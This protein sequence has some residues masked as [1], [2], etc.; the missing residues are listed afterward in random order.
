MGCFQYENVK[1]AQA[2]DL[3]DHVDAEDKLSRW[4]R[5]ME[6]S[7]DISERKLLDRVGQEMQILID[8]VNE[9]GAVG[10]SYADSPEIDGHVFLDGATHI[11]P[12]DFVTAKITRSGPYDLWGEV[13]D[14]AQ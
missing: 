10:R 8:D 9:A 4:E 13:K 12:G 3:P 2:N 6:L 5:F 7:Q 14:P 11:Q 1:G